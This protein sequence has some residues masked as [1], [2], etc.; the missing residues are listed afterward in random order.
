MSMHGFTLQLVNARRWA[1]LGSNKRHVKNDEK[2]DIDDEKLKK[3][4]AIP[5]Q[6][7]TSPKVLQLDVAIT[8]RRRDQ[9]LTN[10]KDN[11]KSTNIPTHEKQKSTLVQTPLETA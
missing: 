9:F 6:P 1:M 11:N 7:P 5:H 4:M 8:K 10:A 3:N 2:R